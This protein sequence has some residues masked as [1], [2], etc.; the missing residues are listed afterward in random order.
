MC[1]ALVALVVALASTGQARAAGGNYVIDGGTTSEQAQV[2]A[3]LNA[4]SFDWSLVPAQI[5]IH[6]V[7]DERSEATRGQI[8]LS[9]DLLDTGDFSWGIVQHE[10]AHEVDFFLLND[11]IRARLTGELGARAWCYETPGL[12]HGEYGCERFASTLAWAYWPSWE[13]SV[14]PHSAG[15]ESAAMT[16]AAF[17]ALIADILPGA[18]AGVAIAQS[19]AAAGTAASTQ[20][21]RSPSLPARPSRARAKR[22]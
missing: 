20:V 10:Y 18:G 9:A 8:W 22:G 16:P 5:T 4:S 21:G 17:R 3:A 11:A 13:N 19:R 15:D 2:Q 12:E 7:R 14:Q 1:L 6:I